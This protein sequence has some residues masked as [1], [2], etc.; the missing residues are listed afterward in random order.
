MKEEKHVQVGS[1]E[2]I[3]DVWYFSANTYS[4]GGGYGLIYKNGEA[5]YE[6]QK[7]PKDEVVKLIL[8]LK[9]LGFTVLDSKSNFLFISHKNVFAEDIYL[10]LKDNG[11][12]VRYFKT[13]IIKNYIRV[14]IGT[15]EEMNIFLDKVKEIL[16]M[17]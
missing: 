4:N 7:Y 14:T 3:G 16:K 5:Y 12:L 13:D 15:D 11:I 9:E 1:K 2:R 6:P 17:K 8:E 10:K